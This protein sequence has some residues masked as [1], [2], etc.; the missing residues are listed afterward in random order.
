ME[1]FCEEVVEPLGVEAEGVILLALPLALEQWPLRLIY[2]DHD[3]HNRLEQDFPDDGEPRKLHVLLR[4]GHYDALY[5]KSLGLPP[6]PEPGAMLGSQLGVDADL[7]G[8][9]GIFSELEVKMAR[10]PQSI[11][12]LS[13]KEGAFGT[14]AR[15]GGLFN[16]LNGGPAYTFP[17]T[18]HLLSVLPRNRAF[19]LQQAA[20]TAPVAHQDTRTLMS[21]HVQNTL[22]H[23]TVVAR[24][25]YEHLLR[26]AISGA[27]VD[28]QV[29]A[30]TLVRE[31]SS[32]LVSRLLHKRALWFEPNAER[33]LLRDGITAG[34]GGFEDVGTAAEEQLQM[35]Q[36]DGGC[37]GRRPRSRLGQ[38]V[39]RLSHQST[40]AHS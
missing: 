29:G 26:G 9:D 13:I 36:F 34:R 33:Y 35:Q 5:A 17:T 15:S 38:C 32:L 8:V 25:V 31:R 23:G 2:L 11:G 20:L 18:T 14:G 16:L 22:A 12:A 27:S 19:V 39:G 21:E 7:V 24:S 1:K 6:G 40:S 37:A 3:P 30:D 4:P 10:V 28:A